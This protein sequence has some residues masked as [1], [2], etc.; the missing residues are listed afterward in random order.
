MAFVKLL[1]ADLKILLGA[2]GI[3]T[4]AE[5]AQAHPCKRVILVHSRSELLSSEPLPA[6]YKEQ[7]RRLLCHAN[8]ELQ[9]E[10]RVIDHAT[11]FNDAEKPFER[12]FLS[13]GEILDAGK[14]IFCSVRPSPNTQFF[15]MDCLNEL[16]FVKI[17]AE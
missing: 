3:E 10:R 12:L 2:V 15:P 7:V 9:L 16:G 14:V 4:A 17:N 8:V 5:I 13:T 6:D 1:N 11:L